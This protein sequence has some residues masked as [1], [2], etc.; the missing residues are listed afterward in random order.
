VRDLLRKLPTEDDGPVLGL[1]TLL[2]RVTAAHFSLNPADLSTLTPFPAQVL[3]LRSRRD[4]VITI[5]PGTTYKAPPILGSGT[6]TRCVEEQIRI[7]KEAV[8][9]RDVP[10]MALRYGKRSRES[11]QG[12]PNL[13]SGRVTSGLRRHLG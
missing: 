11:G 5:Q 8:Q 7:V 13:S 4:A 12:S 10:T 1:Q 6:A 9:Q 2:A 3:S